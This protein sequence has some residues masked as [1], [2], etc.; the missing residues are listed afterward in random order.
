MRKPFLVFELL[1]AAG[2]LP[3][4]GRTT[5][6]EP[7]ETSVVCDGELCT[8]APPDG[9]AESDAVVPSDAPRDGDA[10]VPRCGDS[11]LD[12]GETCDD[13]NNADGDGCSARCRWEARCGDGRLDPGEICDDGN[14]R[15]GDGCRSDCR[16]NETCGNGIVDTVRGEICDST[17]NCAT[18]CRS[19]L[20]CGN[21][22]IDGGEEC[23]DGNTVR[24]DGCAPDCKSEQGIGFAQF[25]F[26]A[27]NG[28]DGCD[29]SG[30]GRPDNAFARG[31]G[32]AA[33]IFNTAITNG[34]G[35]GQLMIQL[36]FLAL[37]DRLGVNDPDL[38]VGWLTGIDAD[39]V[40][41]N[42][43]HPGNPQ[44]VDARTLDMLGLPLANYQ[45]SITMGLL[46][47][48]PED[49][50]LDLPG[51]GGMPFRFHMTRSRLRGT[52]THDAERITG[53]SEG[54]LC[55]AIPTRDIAMLPNF[56]SFAGPG[57]GG[58]AR[59]SS[60]LEAMVGGYRIQIPFGPALMIGPVQPDIDLDGDGLEYFEATP[61]DART[62]PQITACI[63]G[64]GTRVTGRT[65]PLDRR[66][67][68]AFSSAI[69]HSGVWIRFMGAR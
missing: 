18:D 15:S 25:F 6:Y 39:D 59:M 31:L 69:R 30:D 23:D 46:D 63:D 27:D 50:Q 61:G 32:P 4:C 29:F 37:D 17:P 57:G 19:V 52:L 54:V 43:V 33:G 5:F 48:G 7:R 67:A 21:G 3:A 68:D 12:P 20:T 41:I 40:S 13:G 53:L 34:I 38:R 56:F 47:G 60:M 14:N 1:T 35:N 11:I 58:S 36:G 9:D 16:S 55:G 44:Y 51:P 24:W 8:Q 64:N 66:F 2:A 42:N 49:I 45:S 10:R 22:R 62:P 28:R 65:C 26:A